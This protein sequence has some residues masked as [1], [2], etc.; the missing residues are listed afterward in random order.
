MKE[1]GGYIELDSYHLPMI[2]DG[3]IAL[4]CGRNALAYLLRARKIKKLWIP[5][6]ICDSVIKLCE[7]ESVKYT[8]YHIGVDF[9]LSDDIEL[10]DNEWLYF[11]NYYSQFDNNQ[12][13][14]VVQKY[15]RVIVDNAQ[16]YFQEPLPHVDT[17]YTC[18]KWFGVPDG[19]FLYTDALL[20]E[21]LPQDVSFERMNYLLGRYERTASEYYSEY[22]AN[23]KLFEIEPI[24]SISKLTW[25]LLHGIDY[26]TVLQIRTDNFT[27]L[28][29]CF[30][31]INKLKLKTT[32]FM[33][34]LMI[35][36]GSELRKKLQME[37]IY[38]PTLWPAVFDI[39]ISEDSEYKMAKNILP[40]PIDQRYTVDDM[41]YL[42]KRIQELS[43]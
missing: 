34:P 40:L 8:F 25:N 6:Y 12:I 11:V 10:R 29:K 33:Y 38:I 14:E 1:I 2:H 9:R 35:D 41:R 32:A 7:R 43:E 26:S 22:V 30:R 20:E 13:S 39:T 42:V 21:D 37:K 31:R 19:A 18:R 23:N 3:A 17:L 5:K 36:N 28:D 24:K 4:N 15:S 16:S 27:F